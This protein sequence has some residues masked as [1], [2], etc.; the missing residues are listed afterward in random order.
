MPEEIRRQLYAEDQQHAERKRKRGTSP[1]GRPQPIRTP[2]V[3]ELSTA[4][5]SPVVL[6][7]L[8][9]TVGAVYRDYQRSQVGTEALKDEFSKAWDLTLEHGYD[10]EQLYEEQNYQFLVDGGIKIGIAKR[11]VRDIKTWARKHNG[12]C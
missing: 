2:Q 7:G 1:T 12:R 6:P 10:L 5:R 3:G 4:L 9:D 11:F 8:R